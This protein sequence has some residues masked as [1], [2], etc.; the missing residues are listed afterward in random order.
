MKRRVA[1]ANTSFKLHDIRKHTIHA[2]KNIS[3]EF[4][5]GVNV[6]IT[7]KEDRRHVLGQGWFKFFRTKK[8][9]HQFDGN[10]KFRIIW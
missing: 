7:L 8:S 5:F 10:I 3:Q 4:C 1:E 2:L 9:G 6:K